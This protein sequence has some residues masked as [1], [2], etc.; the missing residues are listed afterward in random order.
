[1][2]DAPV[3]RVWDSLTN[4]L[5]MKQWMGEPEME[6]EVL[7]DWTV[8]GPIVT[9]GFHHARFENKGTVLRF[10]PHSV[11]QYSH[12]SS[13]S[14]LPDEPGNYTQIEFR[15]APSGTAS[16]RLSVRLTN[17]PTDSIFKHLQFYWN[18]TIHVIKRLVE[19]PPPPR[20]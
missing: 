5:L 20:D 10:E 4:P 6:L 11:V 19:A 16:T 14:R 18:T 1:M 3:T 9:T 12:L 13:V 8:G 15:L 2:I 17:F 7:T